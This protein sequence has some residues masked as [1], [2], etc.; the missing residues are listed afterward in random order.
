MFATLTPE[1]DNIYQNK[2]PLYLYAIEDNIYGLP[3]MD[4]DTPIGVKSVSILCIHLS[5]NERYTIQR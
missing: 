2:L 1:S 3:I 4:F 5:G